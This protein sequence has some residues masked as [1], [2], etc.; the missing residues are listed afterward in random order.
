MSDASYSNQPPSHDP[1]SQADPYKSPESYQMGFTGTMPGVR[2]TALT[3][4][5]IISIVLGALVAMSSATAAVMLPFQRAFAGM[6]A[7]P[8]AIAPGATP[9][10]QQE[11]QKIQSDM[12][13]QIA[14][15]N[16]KYFWIL[17]PL[18]IVQLI[19]AIWLIVSAVRTLSLSMDGRASFV[20]ALLVMIGLEVC[21][22]IPLFM[23]QMEMQPIMG[24]MM[25]KLTKVQPGGNPAG[26][27]MVGTIMKASLIAGMVLAGC[28][29]LTRVG[30]YSYAV[31]YLRRE[32]IVKLCDK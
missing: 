13:R 6:V 4:V 31:S 20:T 5:C 3:V 8:P 28:F 2:P 29:I 25:E 14:E 23:T 21:F 19:I 10:P 16:G 18:H 9:T 30:F 7:P 27:E 1:F 11:M 15:V 17:M 22:A 26:A 24:S 12:Q 32:D